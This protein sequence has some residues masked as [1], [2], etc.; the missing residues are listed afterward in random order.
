MKN[1]F[2]EM[3]LL[4]DDKMIDNLIHRKLIQGL[5]IANNIA[6]YINA[7]DALDYLR[8]RKRFHDNFVDHSVDLIL[9]DISMPGMDAW[10]FLD[11]FNEMCEGCKPRTKIII[12]SSTVNK[13]DINRA[14]SNPMVLGFISKPLNKEILIECLY[15]GREKFSVPD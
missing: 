12:V 6:E 10:G 9:L 3:V 15:K 1:D 4:I 14:N 13:S 2:F 11:L 7:P 5:N 8:V